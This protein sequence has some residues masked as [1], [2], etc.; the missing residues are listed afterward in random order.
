MIF[1]SLLFIYGFLPVSVIL[2]HISPKRLKN[3]VLLMLS[4][5]YCVMLGLRYFIVVFVFSVWNFIMAKSV[6][7]LR[8]YRVLAAFPL[9][10][11]I[12]GDIVSMIIFRTDYF[13]DITARI[14]LPAEFFP[15]GI[16]FLS[17]SAI[18]SL[19]DIYNRKITKK[20]SLLTYLLYIVFFPKLVMGPLIS[21]RSFS[22]MA[23]NRKAS[24]SHIGSGMRLFIIGL[25]KRVIL[26]Q[27]LYIL[28]ASVRTI[29]TSELSALTA[30]LG[31][32]AYMLCLYFTLSGYSD[33]GA[34]IAA[35]FGFR[36]PQSFNYP[37]FSRGINDF[38]SRWHKP[39]ISWFARYIYLPLYRAASKKWLKYVFLVLTWSLI[40][41]WYGFSVNSFIWGVVIGAS[42][43]IEKIVANKNTMR[44]T[45]IIYTLLIL[46]F[47]TVFFAGDSLSESFMYFLAMVGGNNNLADQSGLYLLKS[48]AVILIVSMLASADL[49]RRFTSRSPRK[50]MRYVTNILSPVISI[51]FL[52]ICTAL[53]S[54]SG[55]AE[56]ILIHL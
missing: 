6:E 50:P 36:L 46:S 31:V 15:I 25:A 9:A 33:M 47:S 48:Y 56:M 14:G 2:Y 51:L 39:V 30:W 3:L 32:I 54:Y 45:A 55:T 21:Y 1:S 43:V 53:I 16:S 18:G 49:F 40:G 27:N 29:D 34:G 7:K 19:I 42:A 23:E 12:I 28:H 8:N 17:L 37:I 11:G 13:N 38:R 44:S 52:I 5:V 22:E 24:L 10:I 35:C 20:I 26:A 41:I 4:V